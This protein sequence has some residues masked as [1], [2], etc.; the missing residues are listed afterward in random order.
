MSTNQQIQQQHRR[1]AIL[2][3]L[4]DDTNYSVN[5]R[6]LQQ[7]LALD[8]HSQSVSMDLLRTD[9]MWLEEQGLLTTRQLPTGYIASLRTRGLDV[10]KGA[11]IAPG[12]ARPAPE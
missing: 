12:I 11:V 5:D 2:T 7:I 8:E 3:I 1:L 10:A 4:A 9:L 6:L